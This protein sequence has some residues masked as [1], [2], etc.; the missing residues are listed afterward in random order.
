MSEQT[1]T[2][3]Y[4]RPTWTSTRKPRLIAAAILMSIAVLFALLTVPSSY[5]AALSADVPAAMAMFIVILYIVAL[6]GFLYACGAVAELIINR[7]KMMDLKRAL[8]EQH[9]YS[10][11]KLTK[12]DTDDGWVQYDATLVSGRS[13]HGRLVKHPEG[14]YVLV[15]LG[16][17]SAGF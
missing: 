10:K 6:V 12:P 11:I 9:G 7:Q 15:N 2:N 16:P 8:S 13:E 14:I 5:N 17:Q 3:K 1:V 4:I